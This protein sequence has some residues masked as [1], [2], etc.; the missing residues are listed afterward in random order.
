[1]MLGLKAQVPSGRSPQDSDRRATGKV[2]RIM[3]VSG[4]PA[5]ISVCSVER[6]EQRKRTDD[7]IGTFR[8]ASLIYFRITKVATTNFD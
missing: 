3:L 8:F 1:M 5:E 6:T 2:E 4:K 7:A